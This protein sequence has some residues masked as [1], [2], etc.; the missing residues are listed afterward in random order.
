MGVAPSDF[1]VHISTKDAAFKQYREK[2]LARILHM[3]ARHLEGG[4]WSGGVL[5]T[6]KTGEVV[7]EARDMR[8]K[9]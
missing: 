9:K 7:G 4:Q 6:G 2:E 1:K 5:L 8:G 3:L